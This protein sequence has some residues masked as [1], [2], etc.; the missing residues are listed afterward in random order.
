MN[1]ARRTPD[2]EPTAVLIDRIRAGDESARELLVSRYL[3]LLRRWAHGRLPARA[4]DLTDTDDLVQI[5]LLRALDRIEAFEYQREGAFLA[6]LR[7]IVL[8]AI[9]DEI[10]RATRRPGIDPVSEDLVASGPSLLDQAIGR[11]VMERYEA[12]LATLPEEKQE[13]VMLRIEFGMSYPEI[14]AAVG[15]PSANAAR[16]MVV[17]SLAQLAEILDG[18]R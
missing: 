11:E 6:Y 5:A 3:S 15:C 2:P 17:R 10:R 4:R 9:R 8:N 16:M 14:A 7:R 12:A 18:T 13:A 1:D